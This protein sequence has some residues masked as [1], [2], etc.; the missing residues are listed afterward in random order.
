MLG[1]C[2]KEIL[3]SWSGMMNSACVV[4]GLVLCSLSGCSVLGIGGKATYRQMHVDDGAIPLV[5]RVAWIDGKKMRCQ[6]NID[7]LEVDPDGG[8]LATIRTKCRPT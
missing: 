7:R 1:A 4:I 3:P 6:Q 8:F 2:R 5:S